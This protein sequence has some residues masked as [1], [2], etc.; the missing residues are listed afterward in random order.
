MAP[1]PRQPFL[2][3]PAPPSPAS[4]LDEARRSALDLAS[5]FRTLGSA[6][7]WAA[8]A[9]AALLRVTILLLVMR[10]ADLCW[11]VVP[12]PQPT[13]DSSAD[14]YFRFSWTD[15]A[16]PVGIGG[17]WLWFFLWNLQQR[18]LIPTYDP[19]LQEAYHHE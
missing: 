11:Q 14:I 8:G 6:D 18:P 10:M 12:A 3:P 7:Q 9:S 1:D 2:S 4:P 5:F 17:V 15:I 13:P 16:A 19:H